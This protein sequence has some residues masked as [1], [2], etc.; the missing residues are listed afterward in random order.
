MSD[1]Q[2]P[3]TII[4]VEPVT[5][6]VE[7]AAGQAIFYD[8]PPAAALVPSRPGDSAPLLPPRNAGRIPMD[9]LED[10]ERYLDEI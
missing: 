8:E 4:M 5:P 1:S 7:A 10:L 9:T 3:V 6:N 2:K